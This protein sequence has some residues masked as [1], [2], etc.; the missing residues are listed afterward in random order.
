MR[1]PTSPSQLR[2]RG[3]DGLARAI[4]TV[5]VARDGAA[6]W[7]EHNT[8]PIR[9]ERGTV[10]GTVIVFRDITER[11]RAEEALRESEQRFARFMQHLPGLAWIKDARGPLRLRQRRRRAGLPHAPGGTLRQDR[12]GGLPARD[13]RPVPGERPAGARRRGGRAGDRDPGAR[14]RGR[15]TTRSSA[16]SRSRARTAGRRWSA[17]W[18]STSPTAWRW[19]RRC[20][21]PTAARTSSWP[22]WP[23][24]S[25]TRWPRSATPCT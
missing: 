10:S 24:S 23:T 2:S 19:R 12:R 11:K 25:A 3:G 22:R 18:P 17:G 15:S 1:R 20:R 7:I 4:A 16:S 13:R 5:L 9:D 8:A 14:G 6:R 21:R